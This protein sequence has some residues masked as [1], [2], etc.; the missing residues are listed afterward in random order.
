MCAGYVRGLS[1]SQKHGLELLCG[2]QKH[3]SGLHLCL[4]LLKKYG[5]LI[6]NISINN[7]NDF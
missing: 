1:V 6:Y 5:L 2:S 4:G 3:V 7:H